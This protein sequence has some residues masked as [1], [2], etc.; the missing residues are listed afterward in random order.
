MAYLTELADP[1]E[2]LKDSFVSDQKELWWKMAFADMIVS[3]IPQP[4]M[5][6]IT[7]CLLTSP[8]KT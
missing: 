2:I 7:N 6:L 1:Q 3:L 4:G 8:T 5:A